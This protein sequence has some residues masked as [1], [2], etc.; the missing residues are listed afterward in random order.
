M[1]QTRREFIKRGGLA[2]A[3]LF[4]PSF[5]FAKGNG[6]EIY[7]KSWAN[8]NKAT[9]LKAKTNQYISEI[10][11]AMETT[12]KANATTKEVLDAISKQNKKVPNA[13][14]S[15][16]M[17][18]GYFNHQYQTTGLF[19]N[20]GTLLCQESKIGDGIFY[21]DW[22]GQVHLTQRTNLG[23]NYQG[24]KDALQVTLLS[25]NSQQLYTTNYK[26]DKRVRN[27]FGINNEGIIGVIFDKTNFSFGEEYMRITHGCHTVAN[28]DGGPS[29]SIT[30]KNIQSINSETYNKEKQKQVL[31]PVP[32][33]II[34]Y[35]K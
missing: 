25:E 19:I 18:D 28:L 3:A 12:G 9:I 2:L 6:I 10:V 14:M 30:S 29:A 27:F 35:N 32:H 31:K 16:V 15:I 8:G 11:T 4:F 1:T 34:F 17:N 21:T 13:S 26:E 33:H 5:A 24:I 20:N 7:Q 22:A 23:K